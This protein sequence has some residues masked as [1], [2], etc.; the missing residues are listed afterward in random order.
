MNSRTSLLLILLL[1]IIAGFAFWS[2]RQP[3]SIAG[4]A[5]TKLFEGVNPSG[6]QRI[7]LEQTRRGLQITMERR[8]DGWWIT[9][10]V[11]HPA[12]AGIVA[13]FAQ[14]VEFNQVIPIT[15]T[16]P[17]LAQLGFE[18]PVGVIDLT[19]EDATGKLTTKRIEMGA[20]DLDGQHVYVRVDGRLGRTVRNI[21]NTLERSVNDFRSTRALIMD[22]GQIVEVHRTGY[23]QVDLESDRIDLDFT[24]YLDG[25]RWVSTAPIRATLDPGLMEVICRA[26]TFLPIKRFHED[27]PRDPALYGLKSPWWRIALRTHSGAE[28]ALVFGHPNVGDETWFAQREGQTAVLEV[29]QVTVGELLRP[30]DVLLDKRLLQEPKSSFIGIEFRSSDGGLLLSRDGP[31]WTVSGWNGD[32][33]GAAQAADPVI[34]A[35]F[36]DRMSQA[37]LTD[38]QWGADAPHF[39][40]V[41]T[42]RLSTVEETQVIELGAAPHY[43]K[44]ETEDV[45]YQ[46]ES[47][48]VDR[49]NASLLAWRT[50]QLLELE[51]V[52]V[53]GLTLTRDGVSKHWIRS[54]RGR[55][56]LDGEDEEARDLLKVM[57]A[58][59][60][61]RG[62]GYVPDQ[63]APLSRSIE[64]AFE[65]QSGESVRF[66]VGLAK[67]D[68]GV[69]REAVQVDGQRA[70]VGSLGLHARLAGLVAH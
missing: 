12:E 62:K 31:S 63:S 2:N 27:V 55:W 42:L 37:T 22:P 54:D 68:R 65:M 5:P 64:G 34:V 52:N 38:P 4:A 30:L 50:L 43:F 21:A 16:N 56:T 46:V 53:R 49:L 66:A 18:P 67:D 17:D 61:L 24:A 26:S 44:R 60:F 7:R 36:V 33:W 6:L 41:G 70:F 45:T 10:P 14:M 69:L 32:E 59:L 13:L 58:L 3:D 39:E 8:V 35:E 25:T 28:R 57:D 1:G 9:D 23:N 29:D 11:E 51:E 47:W 19:S 48:L 15:Q 40:A 20:D